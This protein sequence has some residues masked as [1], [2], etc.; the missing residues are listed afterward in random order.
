LV[1]C[2]CKHVYTSLD[3][4]MQFKQIAL[5]AAALVAAASSFAALPDSSDAYLTG[6]SASQPDVIASLKS[7]CPTGLTISKATADAKLE[8]IMTYSCGAPFS[9]SGVNTVYHNVNGGSLNSVI[10]PLTNA[11]VTFIDPAG[12]CTPFTGPAGQAL[13]QSGINLQT[14]S[15]KTHQS[16]G[17]FSDTE[18]SL[19]SDYLVSKGVDIS[20]VTTKSA[21]LLQAFGVAVSDDLYVLLYKAQI[22]SVIP[23]SLC[24]AA[25]ATN[26]DIVAAGFGSATV[27]ANTLCQPSVSRAEMASVMSGSPTTLLNGVGVFNNVASTSRLVYCR[28]P[29]TSGTQVTAE[30][31]FLTNP[32]ANPNGL[33]VIGAAFEINDATKIAIVTPAPSPKFGVLVGSGTGDTV[34]CIGGRNA[35]SAPGTSGTVSASNNFRIGVVSAERIAPQA[36]KLPVASPAAV[37]N[38]KF[39]R[40]S[41]VYVSEGGA[42]P[43]NITTAKAGRYDL[44]VES[45]YNTETGFTPNSTDLI[46]GHIAAN[47]TGNAYPGVYKILGT[48]FNH[49]ESN[50]KK[51]LV[52]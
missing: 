33:N 19:A 21:N 34:N 23:S 1:P 9:S 8:N 40:L 35:D 12:T 43:F 5:A 39:V 46:L 18:P 31:Y 24:P 29:V 32:A 37:G 3:N 38:W 6:A 52:R 14:C 25:T 44:V 47:I 36:Y 17:G 45:R 13:T 28:R 15:T 11:A 51:P 4:I 2:S 42:A 10:L 41:E 50:S 7:L 49:K 30:N 27:T 48:S 16:E 20:N 22:G 26:D